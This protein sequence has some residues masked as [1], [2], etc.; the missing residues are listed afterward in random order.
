M[1]EL[2]V[3]IIK[4]EPMCVASAL[5]FGDHPE[6]MA[7]NKILSWAKPLGV[8]DD[9]K[10]ARFFGFNNPDPS[11]GSPNY[12]YEQ[13]IVVGSDAQASGDIKMK[14]FPGGL[15]AVTRCKLNNIG[16]MWQRL[17]VWRDGSKYQC[18]SHQC[19]EEVLNREE[20]LTPDGNKLPDDIVFQTMTL[21]LYLPIA[22]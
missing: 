16:E 2:E 9:L 4:L 13:W 5:G 21:D 20:I 17:V 22:E 1:S 12:G 6:E 3:R 19:L 11:P 7:W 8:L 10:T 15:Y 14:D 18:A